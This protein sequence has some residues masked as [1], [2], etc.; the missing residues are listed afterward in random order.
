MAVNGGGHLCWL[1]VKREIEIEEGREIA[2][3]EERE[4]GKEWNE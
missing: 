3:G 1:W 4:W 2:M